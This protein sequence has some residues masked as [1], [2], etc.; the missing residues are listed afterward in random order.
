MLISCI[1]LPSSFH[2]WEILH[3][4]Y[5]L[6]SIGSKLKGLADAAE[7]YQAVLVENRRLYNEVQDLKGISSILMVGRL[8]AC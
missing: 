8:A 2:G 7:N 6:L 3:D 5:V 1:Y 4:L